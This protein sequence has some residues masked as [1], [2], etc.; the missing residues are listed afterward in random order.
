MTSS[1]NDSPFPIFE[2]AEFLRVISYGEGKKGRF[3]VGLVRHD[4]NEYTTLF[5]EEDEFSWSS[6]LSFVLIGLVFS[7]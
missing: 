6:R 2:S 7:D 1:I 5:A 3:A 4:Q